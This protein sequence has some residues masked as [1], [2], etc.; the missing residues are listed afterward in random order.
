MSE[1]RALHGCGT[2]LSH[3]VNDIIY[4]ADKYRLTTALVFLIFS[5]TFDTINYD[6][7]LLAVL[8]WFST[9]GSKLSV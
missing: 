6:E 1:F 5:K 7:I 9:F 8:S 3:I 2:V 4:A